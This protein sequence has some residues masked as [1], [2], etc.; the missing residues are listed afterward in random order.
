MELRSIKGTT[1]LPSLMIL[2]LC[3]VI[4]LRVPTV[5]RSDDRQ[6]KQQRSLRAFYAF[7]LEI[8]LVTEFFDGLLIPL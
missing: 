1:W 5:T 7:L 4:V 6:H 3:G 2:F 8:N